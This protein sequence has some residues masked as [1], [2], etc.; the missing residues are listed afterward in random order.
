MAIISYV[1]NKIY[2]VEKTKKRVKTKEELLEFFRAHAMQHCFF[3]CAWECS[4]LR[5]T[6]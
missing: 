1:T 3:E 5:V 2:S 6:R 4:L